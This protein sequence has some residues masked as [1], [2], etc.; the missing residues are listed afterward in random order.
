[1]G[2]LVDD[3]LTFARLGRQPLKLQRVRPAEIARQAWDDLRS[4]HEGRRVELALDELPDCRADPALL[5]QVFVNLLDNALKYT[6]PR[7][8]ARITVGHLGQDGERTFFVKDNGVGFEMAYADKLFRVFQ[9]LHRAED[10][11]GTG[12]GLAIVERIIHRHGGRVRAEAAP[13]QGA[14]FYFTLQ[15][16]T[17]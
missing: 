6:R 1:M 4:V 11:E 14:T 7:E 3:L 2:Q 8:P 16:G 15:E 13:E 12:V 9:R 5:K 17:P 10:Y